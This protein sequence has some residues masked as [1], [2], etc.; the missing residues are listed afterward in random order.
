MDLRNER[1][2]GRRGKGEREKKREG[3]GIA[4]AEHTGQNPKQGELIHK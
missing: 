4:R 3:G 2:R 1:A